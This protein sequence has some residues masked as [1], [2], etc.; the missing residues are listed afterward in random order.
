MEHPNE[1]RTHSCRFANYY[2]TKSTPNTEEVRPKSIEIEAKFIKREM[3]KEWNVNLIQN[4]RYVQKVLRLRLNLPIQKLTINE[5][6]ILFKMQSV[7]MKY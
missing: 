5:T 2:T 4:T 1:T 3:N 6:L 7:F